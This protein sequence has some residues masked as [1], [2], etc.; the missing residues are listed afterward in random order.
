MLSAAEAESRS[1]VMPRDLVIGVAHGDQ[2]KAY[3][4]PVMGTIELGNDTIDGIPIAV[5]W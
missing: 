3:P 2:A 5:S 1:I 4:I